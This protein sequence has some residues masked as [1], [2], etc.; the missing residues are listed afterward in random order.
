VQQPEE[1]VVEEVVELKELEATDLPTI[2]VS[3]EDRQNHGHPKDPP[4]ILVMRRKAIRQYPNGQRVALYYVDKLNK[5][6]TVPYSDMQWTTMPEDFEYVPQTKHELM[7]SKIQNIM[8]LN[9]VSQSLS[10]DIFKV[11]KKLSQENKEQFIEM[12][13]EDPRQVLAFVKENK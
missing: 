2:V 6:V 9:N 12:F 11:F 4:A 3:E 7:E 8:S 5:Y 1:V 13:E 10:E